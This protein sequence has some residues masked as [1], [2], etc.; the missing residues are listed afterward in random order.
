[1]ASGTIVIVLGTVTAYE[2]RAY[3]ERLIELS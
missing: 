3:D 2:V 1:V